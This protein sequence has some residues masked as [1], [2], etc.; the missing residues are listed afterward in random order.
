MPEEQI[1]QEATPV[2]KWH[3]Y[4][5]F[6]FKVVLYS[7]LLVLLL[8]TWHGF[9]TLINSGTVYKSITPKISFVETQDIK[10]KGPYDESYQ[11][12][13]KPDGL[14]TGQYRVISGTS[15]KTGLN[16]FATMTLG[17]N[18]FHIGRDTEI[19]LVANNYLDLYKS[20]ST[21]NLSTRL[22][23]DL[24]Q[25]SLW[26]NAFDPIVVNTDRSRVELLQSIGNIE[27]IDG[28]NHLTS[29][30][31]NMDVILLGANK[32]VLTAFSLP[33][34]HEV[35]YNNSQLIDDYSKLQY[36][37]MK[38]ELNMKMISDLILED[39]W[40]KYNLK[41]YKERFGKVHYLS[42]DIVYNV[43][44][45]YFH[46]RRL[47]SIYSNLNNELLVEE[48]E[49]KLHYALGHIQK[50]KV[51]SEADTLL[52]ELDLLLGG[53]K[54]D[55]IVQQ[56][57][58]R[59]F[60]QIGLVDFISPAYI[61]KEYLRDSLFESS[62]NH[63]ILRTYFS[64]LDY[65]LDITDVDIA[66]TIITKWM[67]AWKETSVLANKNEFETQS[68][69]LHSLMS[70]H[71]PVIRTPFLELMTEVEDMKLLA[72]ADD[73]D[74]FV[75]IMQDRLALSEKLIKSYKYLIAKQY[76]K[77]TYQQLI[78]NEDLSETMQGIYLNQIQLL[79]ERIAYV[80]EK[81]HGAAMPIN[82]NEFEEY[83]D[84][85][86]RNKIISTNLSDFFAVE[87]EAPTISNDILTLTDVLGRFNEVG[88]EINPDNVTQNEDNPYE[89]E[90]YNGML[91]DRALDGSSIVFNAMYNYKTNAVHDVVKDEEPIKG[92]FTLQDIVT[93]LKNIDRV[94]ITNSE[95]EIDSLAGV[96][97]GTN[98]D[99]ARAKII[100]QK[101]AKELVEKDLNEVGIIF[102]KNAV[103]D[104]LDV[105]TLSRFELNGIVIKDPN[106][107]G[108]SLEI[109]FVYDSSTKNA[110]EIYVPGASEYFIEEIPLVNV[111]DTIFTNLYENKEKEARFDRFMTKMKGS[112][113]NVA[114]SNVTEDSEGV[115]VFVNA[116]MMYLPVIFE[117]KFSL[118]DNKLTTVKSSLL[119]SEN[120]AL[121]D[122]FYDVAHKYV[123]A[124]LTN[125]GIPVYEDQ[126]VMSSPFEQIRVIG[127]EVGEGSYNF[128]LDISEGV[129]KK[130]KATGSDETEL[131]MT[132]D[133]FLTLIEGE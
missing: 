102:G 92:N 14:E 10:V 7:M 113:I 37:K 87:E 133:E 99:E 84:E 72:F 29:I 86:K 66:K 81:L 83:L 121:E 127:F 18:I 89:F 53:L 128:E 59:T 12:L 25:G 105:D 6:S 1:N 88:V 13:L 91:L 64:D 77:Q 108:R 78:K 34:R 42:S 2:V 117:G 55:P 16:S 80:E 129:L 114:E 100:S 95:E 27:Y 63:E 51:A 45:T 75:N 82:E 56:L 70:I 50:K 47:A 67:N 17:E 132:F 85:K 65:A 3:H 57:Y 15:V 101:L 116:K 31:G 49:M 126:I 76:L 19:E 38:R 5:H 61:V 11:K 112:F 110:S 93:V 58:F 28:Q 115:Y 90:I 40:V 71:T 26:I 33:F 43:K 74:V 35:N 79:S 104:I 60:M 24:K 48:A 8:G 68:L 111:A 30:W 54:N 107:N 69:M 39:D 120:I 73:K 103:L 97:D 44:K 46:V 118:K 32:S 106:T 122:Y 62:Q 9:S 124:Y 36:S 4:A 20:D 130:V 94:E 21:G 52:V 109:D 23:I 22:E 125:K 131:I 41:T 123:V 119:T 98:E 96:F